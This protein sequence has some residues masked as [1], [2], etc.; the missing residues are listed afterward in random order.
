MPE[1]KIIHWENLTAEEKNKLIHEKV[2]G[3]AS[4]VPCYGA[5]INTKQRYTNSSGASEWY[6]WKCDA[7]GKE[8]ISHEENYPLSNRL[9]HHEYFAE[10]PEIPKYSQSMD[11]AW[12]VLQKIAA[13]FDENEKYLDEIFYQFQHELLD[14]SGGEIWTSYELM[15]RMAKWTP[16]T[17]CI[18]ALK[19]VGCVLAEEEE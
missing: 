4:Y 11:A 14:D 18:A 19:A 5:V 15:A 12:L 7:C 8:Y 16:S 13:R 1:E 17:I 10:K 2:M 6:I 3:H 9:P